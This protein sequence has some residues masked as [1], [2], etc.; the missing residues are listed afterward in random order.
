MDQ[1]ASEPHLSV[2]WRS[3]ILASHSLI[4]K[5]WAVDAICL[6]SGEKAIVV[7]QPGWPEWPEWPTSVWIREAHEYCLRYL[8]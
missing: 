5:S 4:V 8:S 1:A 7:T 6:P 2:F 3:P